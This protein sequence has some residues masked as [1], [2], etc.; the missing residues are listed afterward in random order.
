MAGKPDKPEEI[1]LKLRQ[2]EVLQGQGSSIA[3]RHRWAGWVCGWLQRDMN[4]P[5]C[6]PPRASPAHLDAKGLCGW[7]RQQ[8]RVINSIYDLKPFGE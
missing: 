7:S 6:G 3:E 2:V 4:R 1:V 8:P 5:P